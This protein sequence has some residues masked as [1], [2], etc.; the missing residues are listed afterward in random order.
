MQMWIRLLLYVLLLL[1]LDTTRLS[2]Q[3]RGIC[4]DVLT[5]L[6]QRY[7]R[8][9]RCTT[10]SP[11]VFWGWKKASV[12]FFS[13]GI[14]VFPTKGSFYLLALLGFFLPEMRL[15][16][17]YT[18][19]AK[20]RQKEIRFL[21]RLFILTGSVEPSCFTEVL[22]TLQNH[23]FYLSPTLKF[24]RRER[25]R[26]SSDMLAVYQKIDREVGDLELRLFIE[27]I[28]QADRIHLMEGIRS[29][30]TDLCISK[31]I[32]KQEARR[33]KEMIEL[34][35]IFSGMALAGLLTYSMLLPWL[36]GSAPFYP[37]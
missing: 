17:A 34:F 21:K 33:R 23:A 10:I 29:M 2:Y 36:N 16:V 28:S 26:N 4:Y 8:K 5:P 37:I 22:H 7:E 3:G 12:W 6:L 15:M 1:V 19:G 32:R 24:I 20:D 11:D 25:E 35:G 13:F 31:L 9:L 18:Y 14:L 30:Q 27:K